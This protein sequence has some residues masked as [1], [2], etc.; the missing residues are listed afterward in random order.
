MKTEDP[1]TAYSRFAESRFLGAPNEAP[2]DVEDEVF[3]DALY[4][5]D[6]DEDEALVDAL[7]EAHLAHPFA[8]PASWFGTAKGGAPHRI[9]RSENE[10]R[11]RKQGAFPNRACQEMTLRDVKRRW[12]DI[13]DQSW[14]DHQDGSIGANSPMRSGTIRLY[15]TTT[16]DSA[17]RIMC[18]GFR[19]NAT[20]NRYFVGINVCPPGVWFSDV[21]ALDDELFDHI[22]LFSHCAEDQTFIAVDL[23]DYINNNNLSYYG[24]QSTARDNTWPGTQYWAAAR[25]WNEFPRTR[26]QLDDMIKLRL[27]ARP[28][29]R[30]KIG[31][32]IKEREPRPYSTGFYDRVKR[33]LADIEDSKPLRRHRASKRRLNN[34]GPTASRNHRR[35]RLQMGMRTD[36]QIAEWQWEQLV[37]RVEQLEEQ[38]LHEL[39]EKHRQE[40]ELI[41]QYGIPIQQLLDAVRVALTEQPKT[42]RQPFAVAGLRIVSKEIEKTIETMEDNQAR[43]RKGSLTEVDLTRLAMENDPRLPPAHKLV[44]TDDV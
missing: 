3:L 24:I 10:N 12:P 16:A 34:R 41:A 1:Y 32:W 30:R 25:V 6:G 40:N 28:A 31:K 19:D 44:C 33:I 38:E 2:P 20:M 36:P 37:K 14:A 13:I 18:D 8:V 39:A 23:P 21:P 35:R 11:H 4:A 5:P 26:L 9:R 27:S 29:L 22:G 43:T 7:E 17:D 15:H 42:L